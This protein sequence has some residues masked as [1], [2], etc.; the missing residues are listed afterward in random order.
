MLSGLVPNKDIEIEFTGLRPGE[1]LYEEL[2]MNEEGLA[3]TKYSKIFIGRP[4]DMEIE[5]LEDKI[6]RLK[7]VV[8][9]NGNEIKRIVAEVVPTYHIFKKEEDAAVKI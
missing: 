4:V 2:L 8:N 1:K 6:E 7:A 3:E 9:T 5:E